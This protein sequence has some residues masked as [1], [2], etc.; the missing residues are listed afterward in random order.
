MSEPKRAGIHGSDLK[1]A[2]GDTA[3]S[4]EH[5]GREA[6]L[7]VIDASIHDL[8][9]P[10]SAMSGW[11]EVLEARGAA[12]DP[13]ALRAVQGL[14]RAIDQQAGLLGGYA[15]LSHQQRSRPMAGSARPLSEVLVQARSRLDEP[16]AA[17]LVAKRE[18]AGLALPACM[19]SGERLVDALAL[20]L[21]RIAKALGAGDEL[22]VLDEPGEIRL[23]SDTA[24]GDIAA[25]AAFCGPLDKAGAR[26]AGL[27]LATFWAARSA[28]ADGAIEP[29]FSPG[30]GD[31][32][33]EV[34]LV[35][36]R[37]ASSCPAP[38]H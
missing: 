38:P 15:K 29:R 22:E 13:M 31:R 37:P 7:N 30:K 12:T 26:V 35:A 18:L 36:R 25:L 16:L 2:G 3:A 21:E 23:S 27:D 24:D 1:S 10:L 9:T 20:L 19:D 14:R 8:R 4:A 28:L 32:G 5:P 34:I 33:F 6:A 17:R 11:L